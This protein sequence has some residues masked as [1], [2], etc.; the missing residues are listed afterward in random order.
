LGAAGE[1]LPPPVQSDSEEHAAPGL[2]PP[3][4]RLPVSCTAEVQ[5]SGRVSPQVNS[6]VAP[7]EAGLPPSRVVTHTARLANPSESVSNSTHASLVLPPGTN[8][9]SQFHLTFS[10]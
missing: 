9:S 2:L 5:R 6:L 4:H 7:S 3:T 10:S 8:T 1:Q